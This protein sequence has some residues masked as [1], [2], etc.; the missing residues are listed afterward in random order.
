MSRN[1]IED[2]G[3]ELPVMADSCQMRAKVD[4]IERFHSVGHFG[5]QKTSE[6]TKQFNDKIILFEVQDYITQCKTCVEGT[7]C[8]PKSHLGVNVTQSTSWEILHWDF[9]GRLPDQ[10]PHFNTFSH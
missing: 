7:H 8:V 2:D 3:I 5:A 6:L 1:P 10:S 4:I 9:V